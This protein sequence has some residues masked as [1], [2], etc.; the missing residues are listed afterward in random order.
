MT[1]YALLSFS[2][3]QVVASYI[4][5]EETMLSYTHPYGHLQLEAQALGKSSVSMIDSALVSLFEQVSLY[6]RIP[7]HIH[8]LST[9]NR[10]WLKKVIESRSYTQF[11]TDGTPFCVTLLDTNG[12]SS[13]ARHSQTLQSFKI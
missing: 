4:S 5:D 8:I 2:D 7:K 13:Y 10:E 9:R 11:Y 12:T 6:D 3:N 1:T